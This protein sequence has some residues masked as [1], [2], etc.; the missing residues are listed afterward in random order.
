MYLRLLF[1][2]KFN[3][4]PSFWSVM[5]TYF[6]HFGHKYAEKR[7]DKITTRAAKLKQGLVQSLTT[8][9]LPGK[10]MLPDRAIAAF[11]LKQ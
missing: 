7:D 9:Q 5:E 8:T 10:L 2:S 11:L 1:A 4:R 3:K 6:F